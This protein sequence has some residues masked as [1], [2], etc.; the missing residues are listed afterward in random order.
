MEAANQEASVFVFRIDKSTVEEGSLVDDNNPLL[1]T[2]FGGVVVCSELR[3]FTCLLEVLC[4][5]GA[6]TIE[7]LSANAVKVVDEVAVG[8]L[9]FLFV[10]GWNCRKAI[11]LKIQQ[12]L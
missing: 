9:V 2:P 5:T 1:L 3:V 10:C 6:S 7:S 4:A 8:N 12:K 11:F